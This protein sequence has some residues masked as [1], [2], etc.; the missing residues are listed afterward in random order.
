MKKS[1]QFQIDRVKPLGIKG[2]T[3]V[4]LLV[5]VLLA[6]I[7]TSASMVLYLTQ[8][9]QLL[10]QNS[11]TDMQSGMRAAATE[12]TSRLRM[13]GYKMPE[14]FPC[15]VSHNTTPDTVEVVTNAAG[16]E[17]IV[18]EHSMPQPSSE[19]RCDGHD[20]S[21]VQQGDTIYIFDPFANIGEPFEVSWVQYSSSNIQHNKWPLSRR[22]P[23]GSWVM[24]LISYKYYIDNADR[25]HPALVY[26]VSKQPP[27]VYAE[28]ITNLNFQY[29]LSSGNIVDETPAAYMIREA[30]I[31]LDG[32]TDKVDND[33][34]TPYR[35][36]NLTTRIKIRNLGDNR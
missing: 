16:M 23:K 11:V 35:N 18:I 1:G 29:V 34:F 17:G 12:L 10:V 25:N 31:T 2:F 13:A 27:Q 33:F 32:R 20:I 7:I 36:R 6:A 5:A 24:K 30:I 19:L 28:N 9:K 14:G 15:I 4:E 8:Q 26:Q 22:Y 3:V 21:A